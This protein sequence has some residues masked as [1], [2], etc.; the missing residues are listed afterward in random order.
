MTAERRPGQNAPEQQ[1]FEGGQNAPQHDGQP[2]D[3]PPVADESEVAPHW[4]AEG[5]GLDP[6]GSDARIQSLL[7]GQPLDLPP[8]RAERALQEL[9]HRRLEDQLRYLDRRTERLV[10]D[11]FY[12][13]VTERRG[14]HNITEYLLDRSG[15]L[16]ELP[17]DDLAFHADGDRSSRH[18]LEKIR[19]AVRV[20]KEKGLA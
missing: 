20:W 5:A 3:G 1:L 7:D 14:W 15:L 17:I 18:R 8:S 12:D 2:V 16:P 10:S 4:T 6:F 9:A 13:L 11:D 19:E